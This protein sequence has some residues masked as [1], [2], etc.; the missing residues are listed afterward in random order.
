M[1]KVGEVADGSVTAAKLATGAV[2]LGTDKVTGQAPSSKI[3]DSAITEGKLA[4]LAISTGKL[5]DN[6]ITLAKANDDIKIS[7][8]VGDET[9][10]PV[11]GTTEVPIKDTQFPISEG[12]YNP[13]KIRIIAELKTDNAANTASL[14][15]YIDAEGTER[16]ELT[17][18]NT[19]FEFKSGTFDISDLTAGK[20]TLIIKLSSSDV[21][22]IATNGLI[23][24]LFVKG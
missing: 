17:S 1:R 19:A 6:V 5:Q 20:H 21:A 18:V 9:E 24:A 4:A 3:E 8:F 2:D 7:H 12:V 22:G 14:K 11:T 15:V 23:E 10:V 13:Q 16:L